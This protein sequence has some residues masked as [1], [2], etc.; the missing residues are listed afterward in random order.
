MPKRIREGPDFL[1][2]D[3][4]VWVWYVEGTE[5]RLSQRALALLREYDRAE[6]LFVSPLSAWEVARLVTRKR[7]TL[8]VDLP[9]WTQTAIEEA[10]VRTAHLTPAVAVG[11]ELLA[12]DPPRDPVDRLLIATARAIGATL[13]TRDA[14]ILAYGREG[15]VRVLDAGQ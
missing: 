15:H 6:R 7:L 9:T 11:A 12:G 10:G 3:T 2:L 4:H 5:A 8:S 1:L 13:L 14:E